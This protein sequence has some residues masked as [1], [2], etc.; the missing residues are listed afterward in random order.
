MLRK[1]LRIV[2]YLTLSLVI[3]LAAAFMYFSIHKDDLSTDLLL[4]LNDIQQGEV[5]FDA[6]ALAPFAQ[7]PKLSLSLV[8]VSYFEHSG[9]SRDSVND[10]ICE[11][12]N[13]Y[14]SFNLLDLLD[15]SLNV[16]NVTLES[17]KLKILT[18]PDSSINLFNALASKREKKPDE[19]LV[20]EEDMSPTKADS[21]KFLAVDDLTIKNVTV[22]FDNRVL[23]RKTSLHVDN[24]S[25]LFSHKA[26]R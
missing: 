11:F 9:A 17:G 3:L 18:Y 16:G 21:E 22:E 5:T 14:L 19:E 26:K 7:F 25:A 1:T 23:E 8:N 12:E 2:A 24:L 4:K 13:I 15:G 6:V 20:V 10:L